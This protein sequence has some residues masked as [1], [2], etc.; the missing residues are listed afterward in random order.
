MA[1]AYICDRCDETHEGTAKK[2]HLKD[3]RVFHEPTDLCDDCYGALKEFLDG[4]ELK[5]QL[6]PMFGPEVDIEPINP[7]PIEFTFT[8]GS[9]E[10]EI[11]DYMQQEYSRNY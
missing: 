6:V 1:D 5:Q 10:P 7:D 8:L 3:P 11:P 9:S 4:T 2:V